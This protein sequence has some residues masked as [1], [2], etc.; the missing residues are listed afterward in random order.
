MSV[1]AW[2]RSVFQFGVRGR[3]EPG[4]LTVSSPLPLSIL[5][6]VAATLPPFLCRSH[7]MV[8]RGICG[9]ICCILSTSAS[10]ARR[11]LALEV[12]C[13]VREEAPLKKSH[14][15]AI[16]P[17]K[18]TRRSC[19]MP[20]VCPSA[21]LAE[22]TVVVSGSSKKSLEQSL[23]NNQC[24]INQILDIYQINYSSYRD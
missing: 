24:S 6:V 23:G 10:R 16:P 22:L 1:A 9:N 11:L 4:G 15:I 7:M 8:R 5:S 21:I 17:M 2:G 3:T 20:T 12:D 18:R 14:R 19:G 13:D